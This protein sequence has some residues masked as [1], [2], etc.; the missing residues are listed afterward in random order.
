MAVNKFGYNGNTAYDPL[1]NKWMSVDEYSTLSQQRNQTTADTD[2]QSALTQ[3][4]NDS[5]I[6]EQAQALQTRQANSTAARNIYNNQ[7]PGDWMNRG[8]YNEAANDPHG[9]ASNPGFPSSNPGRGT[10]PAQVTP[11]YLKKSYMGS[12]F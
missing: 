5:A 8:Y 9:G 11:D 2:Q 6:N 4:A 1:G 7:R 12:S 10:D 3:R